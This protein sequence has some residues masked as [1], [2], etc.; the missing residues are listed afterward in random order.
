MMWWG[1]CVCISAQIL[2][3]RHFRAVEILVA[4]GRM[5]YKFQYSFRAAECTANDELA[6]PQIAA[7]N[8]Y[9]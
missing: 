8:V 9:T 6:P 5:S 1:V 7:N 4:V 3:V 2:A